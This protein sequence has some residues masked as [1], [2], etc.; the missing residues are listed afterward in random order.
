MK[1]YNIIVIGCGAMGSSVAYHAAKGGMKALVIEQFSLNHEK[2]SSHG[3]TRMFR[4]VYPEGYFYVPMVKR[5]MG[6]WRKLEKESGMNL[7]MKT[8]YV[9]IGRPSGGLV[10]DAV[11]CAK[12]EGLTYRV[13]GSKEARERFPAFSLSD[14]EVAVYDPNAG[15][16]FPEECIR[17]NVMVA[18]RLGAEFRFNE[19][20]LGWKEHSG[21]I[22]VITEKG[23]YTAKK[24]V[25]AAGSWNAKLAR[26]LP[27]SPRRVAV[28]WFKDDS[29]NHIFSSGKMVPFIWET[30][31]KSNFYGI[32][33]LEGSGDGLKL[34]IHSGGPRAHGG[35]HSST[36]ELKRKELRNLIRLAKNR[37][38]PRSER[39]SKSST[40]IYTY[41]PDKNFIIDFYPGRRDVVV[42]SPCSGHGFK[43]SSV[44]GEITIKMLNGKAVP[45][46]MKKFSMSRFR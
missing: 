23:E 40:C 45:Y 7:I 2:G 35:L 10:R 17:A 44:I 16:M 46:M 19:R 36:A 9:V 13:L 18:R 37:L 29:D 22:S 24:L 30:G 1:D 4:T 14:D 20:V 28:F 32:P 34:G 5:A 33:N 27:I 38:S 41:T 11:A 42:L 43:F 15:I 8:G 3:K 25:I 26:S 21:R 12:R 6:L 39:P 31:P